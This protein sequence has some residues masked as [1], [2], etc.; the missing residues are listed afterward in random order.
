MNPLES[1]LLALLFHVYRTSMVA[2]LQLVLPFL[3]FLLLAL[4]VHRHRR[5]ASPAGLLRESKLN[6]A[7]HFLD[8]IFIAP[9]VI[10]MIG[11]IV[12]SLKQGRFTVG[13][14]GYWSQSPTLVV[15]V[16]A[17]FAGDLIGYFRHRLEHSRWLWPA[18]AVHHS[19]TELTWL[20]ISRFHPLNRLSTAAL[21]TAF[22]ALLDF[23]IWALFANTYVRHYYGMFIH[24]GLPWTYGKLGRIFVS[25]AM[26]RWHHVAEA[27]GIGSNFAT[28]FSV[29]DQCF[30]TYYVPGVCANRLGVPEDVGRGLV[31]QLLYPFRVWFRSL[32]RD[33]SPVS[34]RPGTAP[35][36][37]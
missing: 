17:V 25:P 8:A 6:L 16:C 1:S 24:A 7:L 14:E 30:G 28:V 32:R 33:R 37:E 5:F 18:H 34:I 36:H 13:S 20:S 4:L 35:L 26:H 27:P 19:D 11:I 12:S 9:V 29:F 10:L 2:A 23:P 15:L 22:L 3:F 21:D 31:S